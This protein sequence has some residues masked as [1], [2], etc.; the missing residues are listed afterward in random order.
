MPGG[1]P[2]GPGAGGTAAVEQPIINAVRVV[3]LT[4]K[5]QLASGIVPIDRTREVADGWYQVTIPISKFGG[6]GCA[7]A[8]QLQQL[9]VFGD[10]SEHMWVG[11][12]QMVSETQPLKAEI[13]PNRTVKKGEEVTFAAAAQPNDAPAKYKWD[14]DDWDELKEDATGRSVTWKF[15][16]AGFYTVT[17]TVTDPANQKVMQVAHQDVLVTE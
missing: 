3:L 1:M 6:P 14:F 2:G 4:D 8:K 15:M 9:A 17:L 16:D 5:G 7:N 13:G 12:V 11:R 10:V